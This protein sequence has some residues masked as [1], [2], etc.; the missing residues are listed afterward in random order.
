MGCLQCLQRNERESFKLSKS[1]PLTIIGPKFDFWQF[2]KNSQNTLKIANDRIL[3][4][5]SVVTNNDF[6]IKDLERAIFEGEISEED[7]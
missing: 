4:N 5:S 7:D 2:F 1:P 6:D 3:L